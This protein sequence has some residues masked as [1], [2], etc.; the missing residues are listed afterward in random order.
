MDNRIW[1]M[2]GHG[3]SPLVAAAIHDGHAVREELASLYE[4]KEAERLREEDPHTGRW[5]RVAPTRVIGVRS[6]FEVDLNRPRERA[7]Y[8]KPE[9]AWGIRVW[10]KPP[11]AGVIARSLEAYD[12]F[13]GA[14]ETLLEEIVDKFGRF[15]VL[16]LHSYNHRRAGPHAEPSD[17]VENPEVNIGTGTMDSRWR[18]VSARFIEELGSFDF[19][20]RTLD[21]RENVKFQGGQLARW[22]HRRFPGSGCVLAVEFKKIFM[23][24]WTGTPTRRRSMQS[25]VPSSPPF[26]DYWKR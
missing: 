19:L 5:T 22:I 15:V 6:R 10:K 20:G 25:R 24:E 1:T 8:V 23:D 21:V 2:E 9:D 4:V 26:P 13:Y 12:A 17:A 3:E 18:P 7:V 14:I 11:E 16:D